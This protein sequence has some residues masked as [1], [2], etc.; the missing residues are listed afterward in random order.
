[1]LAGSRPGCSTTKPLGAAFACCYPRVR[2]VCCAPAQQRVL[3]QPLRRRPVVPLA[4][5]VAL[6]GE[7]SP[8]QA[9]GAALSCLLA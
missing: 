9:C 3:Q 5:A 8:L 2:S 4:A 6:Q 7:R 1:M